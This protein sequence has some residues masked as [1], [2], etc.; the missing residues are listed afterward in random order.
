[1]RNLFPNIDK[2]N[3]ADA[4]QPKEILAELQ[5]LTRTPFVKWVLFA[6]FSVLKA[7]L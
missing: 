2:P 4:M 5:K 7:P 6:S 3:E 1:M